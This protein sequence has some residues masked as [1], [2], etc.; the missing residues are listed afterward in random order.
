MR[1][2]NITGSRDAATAEEW[3]VSR[4]ISHVT[5]EALSRA[6]ESF[7]GSYEQVDFASK[8]PVHF[9]SKSPVH[10]A[11]KSP[12]HL[13]SMLNCISLNSTR[14]LSIC[15]SQDGLQIVPQHSAVHLKGEAL[16]KTVHR[17]ETIAEAQLPRRVVNVRSFEVTQR[18]G[19]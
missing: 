6:F 2:G 13:A 16:Y 12:A 18:T 11:S 19:R 9:A 14:Q 1:L 3:P 10:F 8:S 5:D 15:L 17:G 7:L 4:D